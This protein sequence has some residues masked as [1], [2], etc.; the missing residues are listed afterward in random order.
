MGKKGNDLSKA[1]RQEIVLSIVERH[2]IGNGLTT[3]DIFQI[4]E[5]K[6]QGVN[7]RTLSRDLSELSLRYPLVEDTVDGKIIWFFDQERINQTE[8]SVFRD[9][10]RQ[11]VMSL[12][13]HAVSKEKVES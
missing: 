13:L 8:R 11:Q 5:S 6:C 1:V 4:L 10:Y 7:R 9:F 12:I 2:G 3:S